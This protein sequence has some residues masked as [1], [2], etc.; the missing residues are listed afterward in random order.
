M[1]RSCRGSRHDTSWRERDIS[2]NPRRHGIDDAD[3]GGAVGPQGAALILELQRLQ[4]A[5]DDE[6]SHRPRARG[7]S[8]DGLERD[9]RRRNG[10]QK[11]RKRK[12]KVEQAIDICL[13]P[14]RPKVSAPPPGRR[15][16]ALRA[17]VA[18]PPRRQSPPIAPDEPA[19]MNQAR[20]RPTMP[21][22]AM[23][24]PTMPGPATRGP[25]MRGS[26]MS[27][28][29]MRGPTMPGPA[30]RG[31]AMSGPAMRGPAMPGPAMRGPTMPGPSMRGPAMLPDRT[32]CV[33]RCFSLRPMRRRR[34]RQGGNAC[35]RGD[36]KVPRRSDDGRPLP[37]ARRRSGPCD[38]R[39]G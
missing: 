13:Q 8:R 12:S 3:D 6:T 30:M 19:P 16:P 32:K 37:L 34:A 38:R 1:R 24:G 25:A 2:T 4:D 36:R 17:P 11:K 18:P 31:P 28:P 33:S 20:R 21:G 15:D 27:G 7:P 26:A 29:A 35:R 9:P 5:F 23:R 14:F 22:P 10:S 39:A